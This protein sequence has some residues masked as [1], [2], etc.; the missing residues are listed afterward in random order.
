M[1]R[2]K[3]ILVVGDL[4]Q[5]MPILDELTY[6][7]DR[8]K[9]AL[10]NMPRLDL[11]LEDIM[12]E[13]DEEPYYALVIFWAEL[14]KIDLGL[15]GDL[16]EVKSQAQ[17]KIIFA[18]NID[19]PATELDK[20]ATVVREDEIVLIL[21]GLI[22]SGLACPT[23]DAM[24]PKFTGEKGLQHEDFPQINFASIAENITVFNQRLKMLPSEQRLKF[25]YMLLRRWQAVPQGKVHP[26]DA[27]LSNLLGNQVHE[28]VGLPLVTTSGNNGL[29]PIRGWYDTSLH[30]NEG[31]AWGLLFTIKGSPE[32][33]NKVGCEL[34]NH[35]GLEAHSF[36]YSKEPLI[37]PMAKF[38][39]FQM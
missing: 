18:G 19:R 6:Y 39:T 36:T 20:V 21:G 33:V 9:F 37:R 1:K 16:K 24:L 35:V 4:R 3:K 26:N 15:L 32:Q 8:D 38:S 11:A 10:V 13:V 5:Y 34:M 14:S 27:A 23:L 17:V 29:G 30:S 31:R 22:R 25:L 7:I 2:R 28:V 12:A